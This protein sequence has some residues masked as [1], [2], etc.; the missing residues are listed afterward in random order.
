MAN[1]L[2][3][4]SGSFEPNLSGIDAEIDVITEE[5]NNPVDEVV[6]ITDVFN[7]DGELQ[8][9]GLEKLAKHVE[10]LA[11]DAKPFETAIAFRPEGSGLSGIPE[12]ARHILARWSY[13][14]PVDVK[15]MGTYLKYKRDRRTQVQKI[16]QSELNIILSATR[17][18]KYNPIPSIFA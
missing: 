18:A 16:A 1:K 5:L 3:D 17:D 11:T 12:D 2:T 8:E 7:K 10:Q 9:N 14:A 15:E 4:A 13:T 6:R